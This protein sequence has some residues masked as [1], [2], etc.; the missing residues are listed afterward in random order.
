MDSVHKQKN[1]IEEIQAKFSLTSIELQEIKQN[2]SI[3]QE[4]EKTLTIK[5]S[6]R[7]YHVNRRL[8]SFFLKK[9]D[10]KELLHMLKLERIMRTKSNDFELNRNLSSSNSLNFKSV[11]DFKKNKDTLIK[12]KTSKDTIRNK[13]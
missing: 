13:F 6:I 1:H 11:E 10:Q 4:L 5:D 7:L 8:D 3:V 9:Y 2:D 12:I